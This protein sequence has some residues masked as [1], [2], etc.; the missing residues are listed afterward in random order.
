MTRGAAAFLGVA[1]PTLGRRLIALLAAAALPCAAANAADSDPFLALST[2]VEG[3]INYVRASE[4]QVLVDLNQS[5][6]LLVLLNGEEIR[7]WQKCAS[8]AG[9]PKQYGFVSFTSPFGNVFVLPAAVSSLRSTNTFGCSMA[10][11]SG[12]FIPVNE[13][14]P[15]AH[16]AL[17]GE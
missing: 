6:C 2:H 16:K 8:V 13:P 1:R 4:V 15:V 17:V 9:D 11:R 14:C 5:K 7:A 3:V 12:K 10:V